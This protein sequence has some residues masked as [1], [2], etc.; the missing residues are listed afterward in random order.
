MLF[1]GKKSK[2]KLNGLSARMTELTNRIDKISIGFMKL[3]DFLSER[4]V[5][6]SEA[7]RA[8]WNIFMF[9]TATC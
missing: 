5:G 8:R 4:T 6:G 2:P 3:V 1:T 9:S 7:A